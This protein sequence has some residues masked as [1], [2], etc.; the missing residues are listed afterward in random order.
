MADEFG[1]EIPCAPYASNRGDEIAAAILAHRTRAPAV[2][3]A[4]HGVFAFDRSPRAAVK[5]AAMV[6]DAAKTLWLATHLGEP[7]PLPPEEI[8]RWWTRYHE[9]YGQVTRS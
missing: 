7:A 8:E 1:G 5:A 6:E 3:L 9:T 2:L 4:G